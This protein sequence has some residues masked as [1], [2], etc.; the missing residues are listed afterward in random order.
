MSFQ[1]GKEILELNNFYKRFITSVFGV[2]FIVLGILY[3]P[4]IKI[5]IF[6]NSFRIHPLI[7]ILVIGFILEI[8]F[9]LKQNKFSRKLSLF[10]YLF[11]YLLFFLHIIF[12]QNTFENWK[13][14]FFYLLSLIFIIDIFGYLS[15]K[16]LGKTKIGFIN[17]ISPNKTLEGY[18]GSILAGTMWGLIILLIFNTILDINLIT[19]I[20]LIFSVIFTSILGDLYVSKIKRIIKIKDFSNILYG[21]GGI[22]DRLDSVLPSFAISFWILFLV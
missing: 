13:H 15:G 4:E 9:Q 16:I 20:L 2:F 7:I 18:L 6:Q 14:I 19:K 17:N 3:L 22:S 11:I 8:F 21:H 5:L 12:L 10:L 1:K